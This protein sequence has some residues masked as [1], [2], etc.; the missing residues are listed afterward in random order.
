[1]Q[2]LKSKSLK[3]KTI[4]NELKHITRRNNGILLPEKV[5]EAA[6]RPTSPLHDYFTWDDTEAA[7]KHRIQEARLLICACV[8]SIG[9]ESDSRECRVYVSLRS[10]REKGGYRTLVDVMGSKKLREQ[11]L[12]DAIEEMSYFKEKFKS[13]KELI[14]VFDAMSK[15]EKELLE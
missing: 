5:V 7:K 11:L 3:K 1:M 6:R 2:K 15:A 12:Q 10:E 8:E 4:I 13:L 14:K 9:P